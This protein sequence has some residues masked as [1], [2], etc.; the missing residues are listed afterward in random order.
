M[1]N[2]KRSE[3]QAVIRP[4]HRPLVG[5]RTPGF[6]KESGRFLRSA[7]GKARREAADGTDPADPWSY[8]FEVQGTA[9]NQTGNSALVWVC[10]RWGAGAGD[11]NKATIATN[12]IFDLDVLASNQS[13]ALYVGAFCD[14]N[15]NG[16]PDDVE[17]IYWKT[18]AVTGSVV[19]TNFLLKDFD[20]DLVEDW[21]EVLCGTD[22]LSVSNYCVSVS[23]CLTNL[24]ADSGNYYVGLA[25]DTNAT[26]LQAITHIASNASFSLS[27]VQMNN[28]N[29]TLYIQHFDDVNTNGIWD[30]NELYGFR[31]LARTGC[32]HQVALDFLD[33]DSDGMPDFWEKRNGMSYTN[34]LDA[35]GDPDSD[36]LYNI[37]E[38]WFG[39]NPWTV[40][41]TH[42]NTAMWAAISS[43]DTQLIGRIPGAAWQIFSEKNHSTTNYLRNTNCWA[44]P[45]DISGVCVWNSSIRP[46]DYAGTL[47]SPRHVLFAA[48]WDELTNGAV[49]RFVD[50][51]NNIFEKTLIAKQQHSLYSAG[52]HYPDLSIGLLDSDITNEVHF[53][54]VLP[55]NYAE[56]F[57]TGTRLPAL[58]LDIE[59]KALVDDVVSIVQTTPVGEKKCELTNPIDSARLDY[60]EDLS[61]GDSG[62]P[63]FLLINGDLVII[64]VWTSGPPFPGGVGT[65]IT[66]FT[67]DINLIMHDLN[68][69]YG[70]AAD[71]Q[72]TGVNLSEFDKIRE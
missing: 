13:N 1:G 56:Y 45:Y 41:N 6:R 39:S 29:R 64:T 70:V 11:T 21:Q 31:Y 17:P 4:R 63:V 32:A 46:N 26:T 48:H 27:C 65:S 51:H 23:G 5:G 66:A 14:Y 62:N 61:G 22:P 67:N 12:G 24:Y 43:V 8:R 33:Q 71:Y 57:H 18:V 53:A 15:T 69:A 58:A 20:G 34:A 68:A 40:D 44:F 35:A 9:T 16:L 49:M 38:Y 10:Q 36:G 2:S 30:T 59:K 25:L 52:T 47:I 55:N 60:Y 54:K 72:L 19:R 28:T 50:Q 42:T 3:L 7:R 37:H